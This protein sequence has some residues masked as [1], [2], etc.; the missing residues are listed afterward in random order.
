MVCIRCRL[1]LPAIAGL[2]LLGPAVAAEPNAVGIIMKVTGQIDP[3]LPLREEVS[4]NTVIKLHPGAELTFLHYP[5]TCQL[6]TVTGGTL[7][8]TK[9]AFTTD[10][11]VKSEQ[12]RPC[13]RVYELPGTSGGSLARDV[14]R[15]P[16]DPEIIFAGDRAG[17]V[18]EAAV[19]EMGEPDQLLYRFELVDQRAIRPTSVSPLA[20]SHRYVLK[21]KLSDATQPVD[22]DFTAVAAGVAD[23]LVVLH[24]D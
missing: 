10:G 22:Y 2:V 20:P 9:T 18:A 19:Y 13:P 1:L 15:L 3:D 11:E 5:P 24:V 6:V 23:S 12:D 21:L 17:E 4:A 7:K 16:F 14:L 8:L